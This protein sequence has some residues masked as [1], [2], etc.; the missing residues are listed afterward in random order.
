MRMSM[1][2]LTSHF[3]TLGQNAGQKVRDF[4]E[5][6]LD[7]PCGEVKFLPDLNLGESLQAKPQDVYFVRLKLIDQLRQDIRQLCGFFRT[8]LSRNQIDV[9]CR[10]FGLRSTLDSLMV[11]HMFEN[12]AANDGRQQDPK[13]PGM[14]D[15]EAMGVDPTKEGPQGR[16]D[17]VLGI[18]SPPKTEIE[19]LLH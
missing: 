3:R 5:A 17:G 16:L 9:F 6:V 8:R 13:R 14:I 19:L 10:H 15:L 18:F 1:I 2:Q 11:F 7:G 4:I 12:L